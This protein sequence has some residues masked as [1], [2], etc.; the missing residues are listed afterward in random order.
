MKAPE[1]AGDIAKQYFVLKQS[2]LDGN[3]AL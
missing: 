2:G 1:V 3:Q